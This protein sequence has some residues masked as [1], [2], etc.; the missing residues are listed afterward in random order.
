M[1]NQTETL[2]VKFNVEDGGL[3]SKLGQMKSSMSGVTSSADGFKSVLGGVAGGALLA[4]GATAGFNLVMGQLGNAVTRVDKLNSFPRTLELM[5]ISAKD[6]QA[7]TDS[8]K[9][10]IQGLPTTLQDVTGSTQRLVASGLKIGDATKMTLALNDAMLANG[11]STAEAQNAMTQYA[12]ILATGKV[13]QQ[14]W[15]SLVIAMPSALK[16]VSTELLGAG[17][18]QADLKDALQSGTI[19]MSEFN[20]AMIKADGGTSGFHQQAVAATNGIGTG[21]QNMKNRITSGLADAI[22]SFNNFVQS[23]TGSGIGDILANIGT[24][25][26]NALKAGGQALEASAPQIESAIQGISNVMKTLGNNDIF[27]TLAV[28]AGAVAGA[29]AVAR[30]AMTA[31]Q[32]A[33]KIATAVQTAFNAVMAI[34]PFTLIA[35]AIVAAVAGLTFFFTQTKT[36]QKIWQDLST[37]VGN[38]FSGI[39]QWIGQA[40]GVVTNFFSQVGQVFGQIGSAIGQVFNAIVTTITTIVQTIVQIITTVIQTIMAIITPIAQF[41]GNVIMLIVTVI[42]STIQIIVTIITQAI[43]IIMLVIQGIVQFIAPII[44]SIIIIIQTGIQGIITFITTIIQTVVTIVQTIITTVIAIITAGIAMVTAV[45]TTIITGVS[46][47]FNAIRTVIT[48]I[49]NPIVSFVSGVFNN[50]KNAITQPL[51][52]A[53]GVVSGIVNNI[54]R[55]IQNVFNGAVSLVRGIFERIKDSIISPLKSINL[56]DIGS[57][58]IK[59]LIDGIQSMAD[60]VARTVE[61]I[62]NGIQDKIKDAMK[63]K[64][65]SRVMRDEVG[66]FIPMGLAEGIK[67]GAKSAY[68]QAENVANGVVDATNAIIGKGTIF[69]TRTNTATVKMDVQTNNNLIQSL[70]DMNTNISKGQNQA[71]YLDGNTLVGQTSQRYDDRLGKQSNFSGRY[72]F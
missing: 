45:L 35:L 7:S 50:V 2:T 27:K 58:I 72:Q 46:T 4:S 59:G 65:P 34:N 20:D 23:V 67:K 44:Q 63:I 5:G 19:S 9:N 55:T 38:F 14:S 25:I 13:D 62:A 40:V 54:V 33:V 26:G 52:A 24:M 6:A 41:I 68:D 16:K 3:S 21:F 64:S 42:T 1:A 56:F 37:T 70:N 71:I 51:Q 30:G 11:S 48:S 57:N 12:Q 29:I 43:Q 32:T 17:A 49:L 69:D 31:W 18:S 15:N 8:L 47:V 10:G 60:A 39:G 22:N 36:G 66:V 61:G 53:I 28:S